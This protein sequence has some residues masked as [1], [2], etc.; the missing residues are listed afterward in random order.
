MEVPCMNNLIH[1]LSSTI[2]TSLNLVTTYIVPQKVEEGNFMKRSK[3]KFSFC[4]RITTK[5]MIRY[6][7]EN[8][9]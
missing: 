7:F 2:K 1:T 6:H 5:R 8:S 9:I 4:N 3:I